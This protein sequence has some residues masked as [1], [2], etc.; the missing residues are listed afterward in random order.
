MKG[1]IMNDLYI[2]M[3]E[4]YQEGIL[5]R[6]YNGKI[7]V[8][9][10]RQY[11]TNDGVTK[12]TPRFCLPATGYEKYADRA[13]PLGITLGTSL[14][15]ALGTLKRIGAHLQKVNEASPDETPF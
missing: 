5:V 6:E 10:G 4:Q 15:D 12:T 13:I 11:Q 1:E 3:N 14:H 8:S 7:Y 2:E 9:V